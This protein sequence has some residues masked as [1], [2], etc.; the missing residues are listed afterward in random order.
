MGQQQL[1][2]IILALI[3]VGIAIAAGLSIFNAQR[4]KTNLDD[5]ISDLN[6]LAAN[7]Y[8][9]R[10]RP[11]TMSGGQGSYIGYIIPKIMASNESA[12]YKISN[13]TVSSIIII[14][15]SV[16]NTANSVTVVVD[17]DGKL[18]SWTYAGD[19]Q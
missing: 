17:S 15:T 1:L 14:A 8:Q 2:L 16:Q 3:L 18:G 4:V 11:T 7:A 12:N 13:Q 10:G 9:Y 6:L 19:F 5:I